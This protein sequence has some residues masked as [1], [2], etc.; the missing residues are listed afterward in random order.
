[1]SI[2]GLTRS[3]RAST[4]PINR[5]AKIHRYLFPRV[6]INNN[7]PSRPRLTT[8]TQVIRRDSAPTPLVGRRSSSLLP[9]N[10]CRRSWISRSVTVVSIGLSNYPS[11]SLTAE[12]KC[13]FIESRRSVERSQWINWGA[14]VSDWT[15]DRVHWNPILSSYSMQVSFQYRGS[16]DSF[17]AAQS[18]VWSANWVRFHLLRCDRLPCAQRP[19]VTAPQERSPTNRNAP[20]LSSKLSIPVPLHELGTS[21]FKAAPHTRRPLKFETHRHVDTEPSTK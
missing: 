19:G 11:A 13:N 17:A 14:V 16:Q 20:K 18:I 4:Y 1:M 9:A 3:M 10:S 15:K 8:C 7:S 5:R 2:G 21:D 6:L 12:I